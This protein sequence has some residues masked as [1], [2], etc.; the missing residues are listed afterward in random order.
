MTQKDRS[1]ELRLN[2]KERGPSWHLMAVLRYG[3]AWYVEEKKMLYLM[4]LKGRTE[5]KKQT[6]K[7]N[8]FL[9]K[10][11]RKILPKSEMC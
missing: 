5:I 1:K 8:R 2:P 9:P 4:V 3:K 11:L 6:L 10:D 7:G